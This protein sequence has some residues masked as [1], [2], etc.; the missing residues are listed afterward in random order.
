[1]GDTM[2]A[3]TLKISRNTVKRITKGETWKD[4]A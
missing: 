3:R 1:M 2:I 4:V